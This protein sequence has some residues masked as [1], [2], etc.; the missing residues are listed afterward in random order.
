M[1]APGVPNNRDVSERFA[2]EADG[3]SRKTGKF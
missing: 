2:S 3:Q 1:L